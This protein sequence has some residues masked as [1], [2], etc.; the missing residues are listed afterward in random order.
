MTTPT[1]PPFCIPSKHT[2]SLHVPCA[3][4]YNT[5]YRTPKHLAPPLSPTDDVMGT[6]P[7]SVFVPSLYV[8]DNNTPYKNR[9]HSYEQT[10]ISHSSDAV[11]PAGVGHHSKK[12]T[13]PLIDSLIPCPPKVISPPP[14]PPPVCYAIPSYLSP[15]PPPP[16]PHVL[17]PPTPL[18]TPPPT[19]SLPPPP[20]PLPTPSLPPPPPPTPKPLPPTPPPPP[21]SV[22]K[23]DLHTSVP[24]RSSTP[25]PTIFSP[26]ATL[27]STAPTTMRKNLEKMN[28]GGSDNMSFIGREQLKVM[29]N[30]IH[31]G[32]SNDSLLVRG[33]KEK[34]SRVILP[35]EQSKEQL[36]EPS[37]KLTIIIPNEEEEKQIEKEIQKEIQNNQEMSNIVREQPIFDPQLPRVAIDIRQEQE[38]SNVQENCNIQQTPP[39][40]QPPT[41][42]NEKEK[43]EEE[44]EE[45]P[46]IILFSANQLDQQT[47]SDYFLAN[48]RKGNQITEENDQMATLVDVKQLPDPGDSPRQLNAHGK[49]LSLYFTPDHITT[50]TNTNITTTTPTTTPTTTTPTT[51]TPTTTNTITT[52]TT[53]TTPTTTP[54]APNTTTPTVTNNSA[55]YCTIM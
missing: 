12:M 8:V 41:I 50:N 34:N 44:H 39:Q 17:P 23:N 16:L 30:V 24:P 36:E 45:E 7:K 35:V 32:M 43:H 40:E 55:G 21:P 37:P 5:P 6:S 22:F 33:H 29:L 11:S 18:P 15:P 3:I 46:Q 19:P 1:P 20:T 38:N 2:P 31:S 53:T 27:I 28:I 52:T 25:I 10:V 47:K 54:N 26:T 14:P 13:K 9:S 4:P 42:I 51:T 48:E 49:V